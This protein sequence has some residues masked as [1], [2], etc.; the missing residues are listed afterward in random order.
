MRPAYDAFVTKFPPFTNWIYSASNQVY[1]I[2][3]VANSY[4]T[5]L[6]GTN[7]DFGRA[8]ACDAAGDAFV[9]GYSTSTNF[10]NTV[11]NIPGLFSYLA[12]NNAGALATN[13]FLTEINPNGSRYGLFRIVRRP[14]T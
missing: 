5:F 1:S 4:S 9:T 7:N 14:G 12:T 6:G 13:A 2:S 8:I 3:N 11:T 10:P